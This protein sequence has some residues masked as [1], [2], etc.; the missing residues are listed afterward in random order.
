M[1]VEGQVHGGL[2]DG[3][4]MA[5]M[6]MIAFDED[7]NCLG[8]SFMDYLHPDRA[9][10]P[11]WE[12]GFTVTPSPHHPIGAKG[13]GESATVGSPP[14][15]V[16][17]VVDALQALRRPARRH[18]AD[19]VAGV[20]RDAGQRRGR[21]S[22]AGR[23]D[24]MTGRDRDPGRASSTGR[25][26]AV[27]ARHGRARPGA[28]ARP[29]PGDDAIVLADG[30]DRGLRRR[31]SAPRVR[32]ARPRSARWR[33][34]EPVLLRVLPEG[35]AGRS[36]IRP[37][38]QVVVNPCLSGGALEIFLEPMLPPP[39]VEVVGHDPGRRGAGSRSARALGYRRAGADAGAGPAGATRG[40]RRQPRPGRDGVD[41]RAALDAGV[42]LHRPGRQPAARRGRAGRAGADRRA[43][44]RACTPRR[45]STS[46][47]GPRPRSRCRSWPRSISA[48]RAR[49]ASA[50][51]RTRPATPPAPRA[52]R[53]RPGL[54]HD[55]HG[56]RPQTP[57]L[58][59]D[60]R[61]V[62]VLRHRAAATAFAATGGSRRPRD[63][64][65]GSPTSTTS[66]PALDAVDYLVDEGLATA[67]FLAADAGPAAAARGRAG[68]RQDR[69]GQGAGRALD[70]PLIRLQCYEGLTVGEALYE[71][72]YQRQ[73]L[74]IRLAEVTAPSSWHDA[75][76]FTEEFLQ[77]RPILAGH[78][79][80]R[81]P[82]A[83]AADRR[84]RPGRRRVRGAAAGVPRRGGDHAF[85]SSA[86]SPPPGRRSSC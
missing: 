42:R 25:P 52:D 78:P 21:R 26:G 66:S 1:I 8:G 49:R 45:V 68:C 79:A 59:V 35:D 40:R 64:N 85:P 56:H 16:N 70:T 75:D 41:L 19:A 6:E 32:C 84:D 24:A 47:P 11:D 51:P 80:R 37:G 39:L 67:L 46:A 9:G 14:A 86:R 83:G 58:V 7:G 31:A 61:D 53:D 5:L 30:I 20:G 44:G 57:Q 12:T 17:A 36:P 34:G 4:G 18:A 71:W 48:V 62:L 73:L 77:E 72:N 10:V 54:R 43:N 81:A 23:L 29:V 33:D 28:D 27:R 15:V 69:G 65:A 74:A 50:A 82:T 76:L 38:A 55:G 60:G 2:A 3:V 13:V 63:R 22:D